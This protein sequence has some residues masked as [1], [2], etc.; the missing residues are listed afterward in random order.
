MYFFLKS[1]W[2][3]APEFTGNLA[4]LRGTAV[5][6]TIDRLLIPP[7]ST[8]ETTQTDLVRPVDEQPLVL[9]LVLW[10][11][12][13][14]APADCYLEDTWTTDRKPGPQVQMN[15]LCNF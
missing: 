5:W 11:G 4:D 12:D 15:S 1:L 8:E 14:D 9:D 2:M 10:N 7:Y 6:Q 3:T 13:G